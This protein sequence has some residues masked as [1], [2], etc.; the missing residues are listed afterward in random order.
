[1]NQNFPNYTHFLSEPIVKSH[2]QSGGKIP[3]QSW[4]RNNFPEAAFV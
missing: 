3:P 4:S 1:M 2:R